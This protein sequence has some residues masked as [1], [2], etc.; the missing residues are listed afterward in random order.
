MLILTLNEERNIERCLRSVHWSNDVVVLD[1]GSVDATIERAA[2]FSN[3][4][5]VERAFTDYA[6]QRNFGLQ[7]IRYR[8]RWLFVL[9]ADEEAS[10]ALGDELAGVAASG[11]NRLV[12]LVRRHVVLHGKVLRHN[13]TST[14]WIERMLI[15]GAVRYY[16]AVHEKLQFNGE[17]GR[18]HGRILHHQF[19]NGID[20]WFRRRI[21]YA[22]LENAATDAT[23]P[24]YRG[25]LSRRILLKRIFR[26]LPA[27]WAVYFI[28]NLIVSRAYLDGKEGVRYIWLE[29][30]SQ[31]LANRCGRERV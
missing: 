5:I 14:F 3:V 1:S 26:K 2:R 18:L 19:D 4:R 21:R 27:R 22:R 15:P 12:Y 6:D 24:S 28:F 11:S 16:G 30:R 9:D 23:G 20:D 13:L 17:C 8:N 29:A 10:E 25:P 7:G 31:Y